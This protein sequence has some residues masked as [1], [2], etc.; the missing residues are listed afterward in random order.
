MN[1]LALVLPLVALAACSNEPEVEMKNASVGEVAEE[2]RKQ[3]GAERFVDPG[4][5]Q[6]AVT[7]VEIEAPGMPAE[8][9]PM[10]RG[11]WA[12]RRSMKSA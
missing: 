9:R 3:G 11:R 8:A 5:W 2:M 1:R 10:M 6:Q 7:L 4:K 12:R